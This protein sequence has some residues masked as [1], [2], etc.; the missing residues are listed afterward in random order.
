MIMSNIIKLVETIVESKVRLALEEGEVKRANKVKKN[1][2]I[3]DFGKQI[4]TKTRP[5][6]ARISP[7]DALQTGR[8]HTKPLAPPINPPTSFPD[9]DAVDTSKSI[10]TGKYSK[11]HTGRVMRTATKMLAN[12]GKHRLNPITGPKGKLP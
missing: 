2:A 6:G 12:L 8:A 9:E 7:K 10:E 3:R 1:K 5:K 4:A 11:P